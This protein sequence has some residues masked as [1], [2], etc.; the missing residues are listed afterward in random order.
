MQV[1]SW[2]DVFSGWLAGFGLP[3]WAALT[4]AYGVGAFVLI[5][6]GMLSVLLLIWI[7]RKVISRIQDRIGPNRVGPY[8]LFQ[9]AADAAK[10]LSKED[11]TPDEA[12]KLA[13]NLSPILA[14][15]GVQIGRAHV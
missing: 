10:L 6:Y 7:T 8:G 4:L 3:E 15:S 14:V 9:T 2:S 1:T 5:N 13:Y 12:D 11:I